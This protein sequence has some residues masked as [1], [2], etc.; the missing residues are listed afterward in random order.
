VL[1]RGCGTK[2]KA[3]LNVCHRWHI[4]QSSCSN[5]PYKQNQISNHCVRLMLMMNVQGTSGFETLVPSFHCR[6]H[7][8]SQGCGSHTSQAVSVWKRGMDS[9]RPVLAGLPTGVLAR[10]LHFVRRWQRPP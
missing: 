3:V 10:C 8:T 9:S 7:D 6:P 4:T 2:M 5:E 1:Q